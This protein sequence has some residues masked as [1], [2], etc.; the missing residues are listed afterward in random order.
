[1]KG[2]IRMKRTTK[3]FSMLLALV[4]VLT[5]L[6]LTALP[7]FAASD[8][9]TDL[10]ID[11]NYAR[12]HGITTAADALAQKGAKATK[13]F[14]DA[15]EDYYKSN[16]NKM[17][18]NHVTASFIPGAGGAIFPYSD[19]PI[20]END[21]GSLRYLLTS[22]D[23]GHK[24]IALD[25]DLSL[26]YTGNAVY[27][28][29]TVTTDKVLDLNGHTINLM[30]GRNRK[31]KGWYEE[32][33]KQ[34]GDPAYHNSVFITVD[35]GATL[36]I[37]DSSKWTSNGV[38]DEGTGGMR[39]HGYMVSPHYSKM[40]F[41]TTRDLFHVNNGN[42]VIYGGTF[43]A[44]RQ[45]DQ[46][47]SNF[48]W[49][50]LKTV[51]GNAVSLGVKVAEYATGIS[52]AKANLADVNE[53]IMN[54]KSGSAE[55]DNEENATASS[56]NK[57][58][59]TDTKP[60]KKADTP[61]QK[62][63]DATGAGRDQTIGEKKDTVNKETADAKKKGSGTEKPSDEKNKSNA[64]NTAKQNGSTKGVDYA[65]RLAKAEKG[66]VDSIVNNKVT[67]IFNGAVDLIS[68]IGSLFRPDENSRVTQSI[69]GTVVKVGNQGTFVAYGGTFKGYG[70][71]PDTRNA[72][73]EIVRTNNNDNPLVKNRYNG[74]QAYIYG[75]T[76]EG[77]T[78]ANIFNMVTVNSSVK[79]SSL[80]VDKNGARYEPSSTLKDS[81]TN[82]LE[83]VYF[84]NQAD[85][86]KNNAEPILINTRNVL[87]RGGTFRCYY[88]LMNMGLAV[89]Q[90]SGEGN[91]VKFPGTPGSVNLGIE[92]FGADFIRDG[93]I[94]I[95][96]N[97]GVGSLV[98]MDEEKDDEGQHTGVYHY[99]LFCSDE[100][101]RY[102]TYLTVYP[103]PSYTNSTYSMHLET[104]YGT[105]EQQDISKAWE[106]SNDNPHDAAFANDE[107]YFAFPVDNPWTTNS[108]Y[109]T[110]KLEDVDPEGNAL[111]TSEVWYYTDP[112][113]T[114]GKPIPNT[115][116][117][118]AFVT[119]TDK[120]GKTVTLRPR[121]Y[122][123]GAMAE[124]INS[125]SNRSASF[126]VHETYRM[127][128]RWFR[129]RLYRVDPLTKASISEDKTF[130]SDKP[131]AEVVY[132]T[133]ESDALRC[134]LNLKDMEAQLKNVATLRDGT[135]WKGYKQGE[136]YR[137]VLDVEE[138]VNYG[139]QSATKSEGQM[140]TA[141][142]STSVMFACYGLS[143]KKEGENHM[144]E[145]YTPLQ[146]LTSSQ[147]KVGDTLQVSI[148]NGFAGKVDYEQNANKIFDV[149]YQWYLCDENGNIE[150]DSSGKLKNLIAGTDHVYVG[151]KDWTAEQNL[152]EKR[153]HTP[154]K[155]F[156][157]DGNKVGNYTYVNT[158]DPNDPNFANLDPATGMPKNYLE[159]TAQQ[160]HAYTKEICG[161]DMTMLA[162][163]KN[164]K[165]TRQNNDVFATNTDAIYIPQSLSGKT[166]RVKCTVVNLRWLAAYDRLQTFWSH[167]IT[168]AEN[169]VT[170][171]FKSSN[172]GTGGKV[173][174]IKVNA[175]EQITLPENGFTMV[176]GWAFKGWE[177]DG[178]TYQ[179]G[180]KVKLTKNT[181]FTAVAGSRSLAVE[182]RRGDG[183]GTMQ[184][185]PVE[186]GTPV[187]CPA[188]TFTPPAGAAFDYWY[189]SLTNAGGTE[190]GITRVYP[191]D[192]YANTYRFDQGN[193]Y[194]T[195]VYKYFTV[196]FNANG[197][198]G[199]MDSYTLR[200]ADNGR[201]TLPACTFTPPAGKVFSRWNLGAAGTTVSV[202]ADTV[203]KPVWSA[204]TMTFEAN[205]GTG[206]MPS[207]T[208]SAKGFTLPACTFTPPSGKEFNGYGVYRV[209]ADGTMTFVR[210][211]QPGELLPYSF[212]CVA[213]AGWRN[214]AVSSFTLTWHANGGTG[215]LPPNVVIPNRTGENKFVMPEL[216]VD[217]P[218]GYYFT[219]YQ[220]NSTPTP[221]SFEGYQPGQVVTI[222]QSSYIF[223]TWSNVYYTAT[224]D[225]N[226]RVTD[227]DGYIYYGTV[228][229]G[230]LPA[231]Q[232]VA[233]K[234]GSVTEPAEIPTA[235]G[236]VFN[237]WA[238]DFSQT[239]FTKDFTITGQWS[240][241]PYAIHVV[242]GDHG[243]F[244]V[245]RTP[246]KSGYVADFTLWR[247]AETAYFSNTVWIDATPDPG[248][249]IDE[250]VVVN[251]ATGQEIKRVTGSVFSSDDNETFKYA[252][253]FGMPLSDVTVYLTFAP[254]LHTV[255]LD[256]PEGYDE[257][258]RPYGV[259]WSSFGEPYTYG[260]GGARGG[261]LRQ[262]ETVKVRIWNSEEE[263]KLNRTETSELWIEI[264]PSAY[265]EFESVWMTVN[266][267]RTDITN[268]MQFTVP[269][270]DVHIN[271]SFTPTEALFYNVH[272]GSDCYGTARAAV[273]SGAPVTGG[274]TAA[275]GETVR[276]IADPNPGYQLKEWV[277]Y[278]YRQPG[279]RVI[280]VGNKQSD[281]S[282]IIKLQNNS[283]VFHTTYANAND[284]GESFKMPRV[285]LMAVFEPIPELKVSFSAGGGKGEM[286]PEEILPGET[287]VLPECSF[288]P[289]G[290]KAFAGWKVNGRVFQPGDEITVSAAATVTA[291]WVSVD[292][293]AV[294]GPTITAPTC[295][296]AGRCKL[297]CLY[298]GQDMGTR[299]IPARHDT[300][301]LDYVEPTCAAAGLTEGEKCAVCGTVFTAQQTIPKL[302]HTPGAAKK[303]NATASGYDEV[304]R[305]TVCN[306]VISSKHVVTAMLGDVDDDKSI[307]AADA[308]LALRRAVELENY[309][310]GSREFIA[311]D[312]DKDDAVTAADARLIL[313]A[314][315]ELEDPTKW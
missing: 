232:R 30:Y 121:D 36:T 258:N 100:E 20:A 75:G 80:V 274:L 41:Y 48:S 141:K 74:G 127:T 296:A 28:T 102:K 138:Y 107:K 104:Y 172:K 300:V 265:C 209:N 294:D 16:Y 269:D 140:P 124:K 262:G 93:R 51:L 122:F 117:S 151:Q 1:M 249:M 190:I 167:P 144:V 312:V 176:T 65:S 63:N 38:T 250:M 81:E 149:Y 46:L 164:K 180:Q 214:K 119:G 22:K 90:G 282:D 290:C 284:L 39:F 116:Y 114:T 24:Y 112:V 156:D 313:R 77:Y 86:V 85:V 204:A 252:F 9:D 226:V 307:T 279:K 161:R 21:P 185:L 213:R 4:M 178:K 97:Y 37:I 187:P 191:G 158:V 302:D 273:G 152:A 242:G 186:L 215:T 303:E 234:F 170:A 241:K 66:V 278:D 283:F 168:I 189:V 276:L 84:E 87:V 142:A 130:G 301:L 96:D 101:L 52:A 157:N 266:G 196:S 263:Y 239:G 145:D 259:I 23:E 70:S 54:E 91:F 78:G 311:C 199:S 148:R 6:P 244:K 315:V 83:Q 267:V 139:W 281:V 43:Q 251:D 314:A 200:K 309:A 131:L 175:G 179:P 94:Q 25:R 133:S 56:T 68:D 236:F 55:N 253:S 208:A 146:W 162:A 62:A 194:F 42:L 233:R 182:F 76:F 224:F 57:K 50:K 286:E 67:D 222:T 289:D 44:G 297:V 64:D 154:D 27:K 275:D 211:A 8:D 292:H 31:D 53:T 238:H 219:G 135:R 205:G 33:Y 285:V 5:S 120:N 165:V 304:V 129:Y 14:T 181:V 280:F 71:T 136:L 299:V 235:P 134:I 270:A 254:K 35:E 106:I 99:R 229:E 132:G 108:Y 201:Y 192:S 248:Y 260:W 19:L 288:A 18:W 173:D 143:E 95:V 115:I 125:L 137:I 166:I 103:N 12:D 271:A 113:S 109:V 255:A 17:R 257:Y 7:A 10:N 306:T 218:A 111:G 227:E 240:L 72:V 98:L 32:H 61:E 2:E 261:A 223:P 212:N 202:T 15:G 305:C 177:A 246:E 217:P 291:T 237:G 225:R 206:T 195:A 147:P 256:W 197:G 29:M 89:D 159:W 220:L 293:V 160:I 193:L 34:S 11:F 49:S 247:E 298:C 169:K 58:D 88:E 128:M 126:V 73:V 123:D 230:S 110:P 92:S 45:K 155:W 207:I 245:K 153:Y 308:R 118:D 188:C 105:A 59:G 171:S 150:K 287:F 277:A 82:G 79:R 60:E 183:T 216:M 310:P 174:D 272:V 295:T 228:D 184:P 13:T 40:S 47:K 243:T 268:T 231:P 210:M 163:D 26:S 3:I 69:M 221:T 264:G 198:T 203:I